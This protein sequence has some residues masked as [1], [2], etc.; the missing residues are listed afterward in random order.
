MA[1]AHE[2]TLGLLCHRQVMD[3]VSPRELFGFASREESRCGVLLD[4]VEHFVARVRTVAAKHNEALVD[5]GADAGKRVSHFPNRSAHVRDGV[6][7]P[8]AREH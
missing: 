7:A 3:C 8:S 1:S 4:D 2:V 6:Q 5:E